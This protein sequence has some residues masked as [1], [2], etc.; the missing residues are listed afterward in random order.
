MFMS[1]SFAGCNAA[2]K[3]NYLYVLRGQKPKRPSEKRR[4]RNVQTFLLLG[5]ISDKQCFF[6]IINSNHRYMVAQKIGTIFCTP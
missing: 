2:L 5:I 4:S 1:L 3:T 6:F